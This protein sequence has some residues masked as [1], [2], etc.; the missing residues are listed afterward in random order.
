MQLGEEEEVEVDA[1]EEVGEEVEGEVG[2]EVQVVAESKSRSGSGNKC[3][4]LG[5]R[6][7]IGSRSGNFVY[8]GVG[9]GIEIIIL[10]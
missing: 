5:N 6:K 3:G 8:V 7:G 9:V 10:I 4:K 2:E 1:G